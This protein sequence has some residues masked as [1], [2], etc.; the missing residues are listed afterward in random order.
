MLDGSR[1][2]RDYYCFLYSSRICS[3]RRNT[4]R[5][6]WC[7]EFV[8]RRQHASIRDDRLCYCL[9]EWKCRD[10]PMCSD[11]YFCYRCV[12]CG[13]CG[14]QTET[15]SDRC[16]PSSDLFCDKG[17][18]LIWRRLRKKTR[19]LNSKNVDPWASRDPVC[20]RSGFSTESTG[21]S[22]HCARFRAICV[23]V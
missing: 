21:I 11:V 16:W 19:S 18:G 22:E 17:V 2:S 14:Y 13:F 15:K 6:I 20:R 12:C 1:N 5:E 4:H 8:I 10:W 9:S 7:R 3:T 23:H